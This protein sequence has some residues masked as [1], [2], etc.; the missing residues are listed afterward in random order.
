[1]RTTDAP[2]HNR[3]SHFRCE[4]A[5][6][7][8][9]QP[10]NFTVTVETI[11]TNKTLEDVHLSLPYHHPENGEGFFW[12]PEVGALVWLAFASD[13]TPPFVLGF[14]SAPGS[15]SGGDRPLRTDGD[16]EGSTTD[17]TYRSGRPELQPGDMCL[18][19]RDGN[20]IILRRGGVLQLGATP[21]A[22]RVFVPILN[23]VKD[24][25]ENY[26]MDVLGGDLRWLV[27]R[28]ESDASGQAPCEWRM[29]VLGYAQ[30]QKATVRVR[31]MALAAPGDAD[32]SA[33]DVVVS[34]NGIDKDTGE[35]TGAVYSMLVTT[36]GD[37]TEVMASRTT[38]INGDDDLRIT[39]S[40][41]VE[42]GGN[43]T[44]DV[45][46]SLHLAAGRDAIL[47]GARVLVGGTDAAQRA[48]LGDMLV[49]WLSS[50]VWPVQT[51]GTA[52]VA[53]PS[54]AAIAAL[55]QILSRT[56]FVK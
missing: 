26:S 46:G 11:H 51:V 47:E 41:S 5:V 55:Q 38:T 22:Q 14:R 28:Q 16:D 17:V 19:G 10:S 34:A 49:T 42:V 18:L 21:L 37:K 33:W 39:G 13:N 48:V 8:K 15:V 40:R 54:P 29:H 1:V 27:E 4:E 12:M 23:F 52:V 50:Q 36:Q 35:V 6:V 9:V 31:H 56:V 43:D 3:F 25:A 2:S 32:R 30:D 20:F 44:L 53:S 45:T 7:T 24:Y